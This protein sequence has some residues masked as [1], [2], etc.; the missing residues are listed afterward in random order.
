MSS[1]A[2]SLTSAAEQMRSA[3][4]S[5]GLV[6]ARY[7]AALAADAA[8]PLADYSLDGESTSRDN[9]RST[10]A[11]SIERLTNANLAMM[12]QLIALEGPV[13]LRVVGVT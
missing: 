4:A 1:T 8:N 2:E 12:Q 13:E 10:L 11:G 5:N 3:I 7:S 9:W 6:I